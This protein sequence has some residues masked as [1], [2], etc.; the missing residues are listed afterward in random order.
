M[1]FR[2]QNDPLCE[3]TPYPKVFR[4][5]KK[6]LGNYRKQK[7]GKAPTNG[8]E[9]LREFE[10]DAVRTDYGY[11]VLFEKGPLFNDVV[12]EDNFEYCVFSSWK[13]IALVLEYLPEL[14]RFF[15][16]DATFRITPKGVWQQVLILHINFGMKVSKTN[17]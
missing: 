5:F 2:W 9:V 15:I 17:R 14:M 7:Y 11:S 16:L 6:T 10:K 3:G 4:E 8:E 12:I 1:I 13:S